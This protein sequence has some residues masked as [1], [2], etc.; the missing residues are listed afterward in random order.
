MVRS[1]EE[2]NKLE[3]EGLRKILF[4]D[5]WHFCILHSTENIEKAGYTKKIGNKEITIELNH[6]HVDED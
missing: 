4:D 6:I 3:K 2:L 1:Y 5:G